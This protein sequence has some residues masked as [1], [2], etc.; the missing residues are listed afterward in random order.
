MSKALYFLK[1]KL[2]LNTSKVTD[3]EKL[4]IEE[5]SKF[6]VTMY[7]KPWFQSPLPSIAMSLLQSCY[8]HLWYLVPQ[9]VVF[10]LA[11]SGLANTQREEM[12]KSST[13]KEERK[14]MVEDLLPPI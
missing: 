7:V 11:D 8:R 13:A 2:L 4:Q 1:M 12:A 10:A 6:V 14:W 5:I 3:E 9:T